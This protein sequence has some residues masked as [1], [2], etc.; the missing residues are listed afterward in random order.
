MESSR[1]PIS[2]WLRALWLIIS[3]SKGISSLKL[4]E[5][6]GIQQRSAWFLAHRVRTM[7]AWVVCEPISG[8]VVE[9]D[10]VY[11]G[12]PPRQKAGGGPTGV[13]SGHSGG[14]CVSRPVGDG[15]A[16]RINERSDRC[17]FH[18]ERPPDR[19]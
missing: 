19:L 13:P 10:E 11:A 9:L 15:G 6:L 8:D 12:A 7:M 2:I 1:L 3:S 18:P 5:I 17:G 16:N 14:I 4:A